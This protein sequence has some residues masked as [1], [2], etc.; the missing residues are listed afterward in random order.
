MNN[1]ESLIAIAV[2][3]FNGDDN[4]VCYFWCIISIHNILVGLR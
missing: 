2:P 1:Y 4:G 3:S